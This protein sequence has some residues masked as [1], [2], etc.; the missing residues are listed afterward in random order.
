MNHPFYASL[1]AGTMLLAAACHRPPCLDV[2]TPLLL[3]AIANSFVLSFL[4]RYVP[5]SSHRSSYSRVQVLLEYLQLLI[6][7]GLGAP[8]ASRRVTSLSCVLG[9]AFA[10]ET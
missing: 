10:G 7:L 6:R 4:Q 5:T 3:V 2:A 8:D 9:R 1:K